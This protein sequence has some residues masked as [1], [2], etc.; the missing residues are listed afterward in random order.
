MN[1]QANHHCT[2][3]YNGATFYIDVFGNQIEKELKA[4]KE[5]VAKWQNTPEA[6]PSIDF[7]SSGEKP[8][9]TTPPAQ[10]KTVHSHGQNVDK[11]P[12]SYTKGGSSTATA[13][14]G[15]DAEGVRQR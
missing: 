3:T 8:A 6:R 12:F 1:I 5:E 10:F 14:A 13:N 11:I 2:A 4:M 15:K 9:D 7:T